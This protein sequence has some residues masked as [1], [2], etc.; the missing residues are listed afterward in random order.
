MLSIF[1]LSLWPLNSNE[2][3]LFYKV[4]FSVF[5]SYQVSSIHMAQTR[6]MLDLLLL[7]V[8]D[9]NEDHNQQQEHYSTTNISLQTLDEDAKMLAEKLNYFSKYITR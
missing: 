1:F 3:L 9:H 4:L 7:V 2:L 5:L 8:P 6:W